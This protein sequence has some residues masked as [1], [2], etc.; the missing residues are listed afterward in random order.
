MRYNSIERI[1]VNET[2]RIFIREFDWIFREQP[3]VDIGIDALVEQS[4]NGNPTGKFIALQIKSGKGNFSFSTNKLTYYISN[5]H[6]NYWMNFDIPILLI[7]HVPEMN[8]TYWI[9][10]SDKKIK[11]TKKQWKI[12]IPSKNELNKNAKPLITRLLTKLNTEYQS[13]KIFNGENVDEQTIYDIIEKSEC[14]SDSKYSTIK[15]AEI[16]TEL[17]AKTNES[18]TKFTHYNEIGQSYKTP[19][20]KASINTFA[21]QIN[22]FAKRLEN[23]NQIFA[24]TFAEGMF[25]F[26]QG[27]I[28]HYLL[29]QNE[30]FARDSIKSVEGIPSA[31]DKTLDAVLF[32]RTSFEKIPFLNKNLKESQNTMLNVID[33]I[34]SDYKDAKSITLNLIKSVEALINNNG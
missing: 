10:I 14:I 26:E 31:L 6:Y 22:L 16:L 29:S 13:I 1:G 23:E 33:S 32:M 18:N 4:E 12:E 2:E 27:I 9:E 17:S 11:P 24:E 3:I 30:K 7:A 15:T 8:K 5:I 28:I 25:A 34:L 19:Q 21:K 20:V